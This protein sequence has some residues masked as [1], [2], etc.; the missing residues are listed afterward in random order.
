MQLHLPVVIGLMVAALILAIGAKR[1]HVPYNVALVVGG[2]L[3]TLSHVLPEA[4]HLEPEVVFLVC[5]PALLFEGG[6]TA[7]LDSIRANL[8]PIALLAT[9]G[10][11]VAIGATGGF[12]HLALALP[13]GPAVLLGCILAVTDTVSILFAFRRAAV[14]SRLAAIVL[15][16]SLFNDGTALVAYAAISGI[17]AGGA[18]TVPVLAAKVVVATVGGLAVGLALGTVGSFVIRRTEDPLA[19]IM[20]TTALAFAAFVGAEELHVSGAIA[21]VTAGLT[22][23]ATA[24]RTLS[25]S[26]Q[27]A[28]HSFWEYMAF[29]VN[30]FLFLLVGLSSNPA[31]LLASAPQTAIAVACVF[32]GRAVAIYLPFLFL[33]VFRPSQAVPP[34]W[35]H[36]FVIGNIKGALSIALALGLPR[37]T[38]FRSLLVEVAFG[39]T[40]ISLVV[41]GLMLPRMLDWL[42]LTRR[43]PLAIAVAEQ[44]A[45]LITAR[46][47][48]AE[49]DTLL[50]NGMVPRMAYE[51]LR[52]EYQVT[53]AD[54]E[55]ELR[56]IQERN[57]AQ[58]ARFLLAIRR[59]LIDAERA[60]L[61]SAERTG[62]ISTEVAERAL[63]LLDERTLG[64]ERLL[65]DTGEPDYHHERGSAS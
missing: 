41:Q 17:V 49:L 58:G 4:P 63:L 25:P 54:A 60:A 14:P 22:V 30:T 50:A 57:L 47:A 32:A 53:I 19:E 5:L 21:G 36:V 56:R 13:W 28:I 37:E 8:L 59:R 55:R 15:G 11:I 38:P 26:S 35:Q 45:K 51:H 29:G 27:V 6:F 48:R 1:A 42:G 20:A 33:G 62:L 46:A 40:F 16:E 10:V 23:G 64:L 43:D 18:V 24:R 3:I 65:H 34:R 52:S 44:Q 39:V 31:T 61:T 9:V 2:M 12:L 7:H